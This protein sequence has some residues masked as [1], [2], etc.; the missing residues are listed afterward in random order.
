ML[1]CSLFSAFA[2]RVSEKVTE[3]EVK[4]ATGK[5]VDEEMLS[6]REML[7]NEATIN[8]ITNPRDYQIE[9]FL[10]AKKENIIAVLDTGSGKTHIATLLIRDVLE[11][12]LEHRA[13]GGQPRTTFFL[14]NSV[15]LVFQQ[16]N[17]LRHGV[18]Q[19]V[20]GIC[21]AM[22]ASLFDRA[23]WQKHFEKNMV[24]VCTA[25]VLSDCLMHGYINMSRINLLI[26]DEAHHCKGNQSAVSVPLLSIYR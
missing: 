11:A 5:T 14:V 24:I 8:R 9:L 3:K 4:E 21:G 20:E 13:N 7:E 12:E 26:F 6:L 16:A 19:Q 1:T 2:A 22:G 18:D 25:E 17:V 10:K 23:T 15:N